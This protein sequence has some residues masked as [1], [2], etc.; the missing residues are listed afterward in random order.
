M[1]GSIIGG[2]RYYYKAARRGLVCAVPGCPNTWPRRDAQA[3]ERR[4][5]LAPGY[6]FIA[7]RR[8]TQRETNR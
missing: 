5:V 4:V 8:L 6:L 7:V 3:E 2:G 1:F